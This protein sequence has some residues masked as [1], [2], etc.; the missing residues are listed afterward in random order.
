MSLSSIRDGGVHN[1]GVFCQCGVYNEC[2]PS[3]FGCSFCGPAY[4]ITRADKLLRVL[5]IYYA[6]G[7]FVTRADTYMTYCCVKRLSYCFKKLIRF[8]KVGQIHDIIKSKRIEYL[9]NYAVECE[10]H[11]FRLFSL[12]KS[13]RDLS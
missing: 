7:R 4:F 13:S 12:D 2:N 9:E 10:F 6:C 11:Q 8:Y 1:G 3:L 5:M